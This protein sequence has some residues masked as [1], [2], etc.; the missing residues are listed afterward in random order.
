MLCSG[1][2]IERISANEDGG[3]SSAVQ[4]LVSGGLYCRVAVQLI[5]N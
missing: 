1:P 5:V 4:A 3:F 2:Y